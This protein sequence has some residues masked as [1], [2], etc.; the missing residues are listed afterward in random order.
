MCCAASGW[1]KHPGLWVFAR[2][3]LIP[4][5]LKKSTGP[6]R[7]ER[8]VCTNG[9]GQSLFS[10]GSIWNNYL[11][12]IFSSLSRLVTSAFI[13]SDFRL[14]I[15]VMCE[16]SHPFLCLTRARLCSALVC[17]VSFCWSCY[18][19]CCSARTAECFPSLIKAKKK[20]PH[21]AGQPHRA[22]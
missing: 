12:S 16:C 22:L 5:K 10:S 20:S 1:K 7:F 4:I 14:S 18:F 11:P 2:V 17:L 19:F 8:H 3:K 15:N 21:R 9:K 6:G 13:G